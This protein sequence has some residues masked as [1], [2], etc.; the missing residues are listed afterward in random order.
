MKLNTLKTK[1]LNAASPALLDTAIETFVRT[2]TEA[3]FL[4]VDYCESGGNYSV[5]ITYT[6]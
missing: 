2:L 4:S 1:T 3:V 6:L 5:F